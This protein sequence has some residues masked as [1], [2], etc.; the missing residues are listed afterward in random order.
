MKPWH[1]EQVALLVAGA[2]LVAIWI[3]VVAPERERGGRVAQELGKLEI[4]AR[5]AAQSV[6]AIAPTEREVREGQE[7]LR[8]LQDRILE[9]KDV[10]WILATLS[11]ETRMLGIR[12]VSMRPLAERA[13]SGIVPTRQLPVELE[14]QGRFLDLGRYLEGLQS[15][16]FLFTVEG[17]QVTR[18]DK[19]KEGLRLAMRLV[20]VAHVRPQEP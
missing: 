19:E 8:R 6:A 13:A 18:A 16:P 17:V 3:L 2:L 20:A 10:G 15:A 12:I 9:T 1:R 11:R 5:A 4:Q 14:I 7:R